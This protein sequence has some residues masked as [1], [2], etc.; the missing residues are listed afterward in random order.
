[1]LTTYHP[2]DYSAIDRADLADTTRKQY[3]SAIA[4][5]ILSHVDPFNAVALADYAASLPHSSRAFL[6]AA[7][8]LMASEYERLLKAN[9]T[10][11]NAE[12]IQVMLWKLEAMDKA[13]NVHTPE[14][15]AASIWLSPAQIEQITSL[16]ENTLQGRRDWIILATLLGAGLRRSEMAALTFDMLKRQPMPDGQM[17]AVLDITGKGDKKRVIPISPLL[18]KRLNEWKTEVGDGRVARSVNKAGM[19]AK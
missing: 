1:M 4:R 12:A 9:A 18:E 15:K 2:L 7:L 13:I 16:P 19:E 3:K 10:T 5:L 14:G 6:K 11:E 17:R 8:S